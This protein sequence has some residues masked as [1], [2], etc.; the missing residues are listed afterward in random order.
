MLQAFD[1]LV[2]HL[3]EPTRRSTATLGHDEPLIEARRSAKGRERNGVFVRSNLMER[4]SQV[5]QGKH[6]SFS[7]R[8]EDLVHSRNWQLAQTADLVEFLVV[9]GDSSRRARVV[10][11]MDWK[12]IVISRAGSGPA[13]DANCNKTG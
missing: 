12:P 10:K 4:R 13:D 8:V 9:D 3:D 11:G 5:E 1:H 7:Q 6:T 2:D